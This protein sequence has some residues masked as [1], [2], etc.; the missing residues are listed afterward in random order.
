M[1]PAAAIVEIQRE[2]VTRQVKD[3]GSTA[4]GTHRE[5]M[6]M[7]KEKE[8]EKEI[9]LNE[10]TM[11]AESCETFV[12]L[13]D[14][15]QTNL[16]KKKLLLH[17]CCGPCS[18]AV[19]ERLLPDYHV[20]VFF[21]NPNIT[22]REE[23]E[24]R[25]ETQLSFIKQY[26]EKID[27]V[28]HIAFLEGAYDPQRFYE[29]AAGLE[30]EPEGGKRCQMCFW[31]RLCETARQAREGGFETFGTTLTVSPHKDYDVITMIGAEVAARFGVGWL[32]MDF[33]KKAG[34]QRSIELSKK[35]NLYRQRFCGCEYSK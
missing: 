3:L 32:D 12:S 24:R 8:K 31:L 5:L 11:I 19:I 21:Y 23:Y 30:A 13:E 25:K 35:Y 22:D 26:N 33:K 7:E 28:D 34:F 14:F 6:E 29:A 27:A 16:S 20:T 17:S 10:V 9:K 18:T 2:T 15:G 1:R 4:S